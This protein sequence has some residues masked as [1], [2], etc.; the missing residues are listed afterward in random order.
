MSSTIDVRTHLEVLDRDACMCLLASARLG[1]LAVVVEG[2]PVVF[3]V[4][5]VLDGDAVVFRTGG[6]TKL[7]AAVGNEVAFEIDGSDGSYHTGWSVLVGGRAEEIVDAR[8]LERC[9]RLP[10]RPWARGDVSHWIRIRPRAVTGRRIPPH[11]IDLTQE[12]LS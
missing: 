1:R 5:Y 9:A 11:G 10:L 8:D 4:N 2:R 6:G 7:H 12:E 3:P